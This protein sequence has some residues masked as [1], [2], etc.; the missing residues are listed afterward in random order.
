MR[1]AGAVRRA[2]RMLAAATTVGAAL[3]AQSVAPGVSSPPRVA[4]ASMS[5]TSSYSIDVELDV[6]RHT[7]VGREVITW[8]NASPR[9]TQEI[10][11]HLYW[12]A[13]R[14]PQ[15]TFLREERLAGHG[16]EIDARRSDEWAAIDVSA[17]RL[18]GLGGAP[19][20]DLT[21]RLRY[22]A[23]DTGNPHDRTV[24]TVTLPTTIAP[25]ETTNLA[26][27]WTS[28]V[29][30]T[31]ARTGRIGQY[32]FIA[33]WFPKVGVFEPATSA[34]TSGASTGTSGGWNTH[35]FHSTTEFFA[36]YGSYDVRITVPAGWMVGA[37]GRADSAPTVRDGKAT[38]RYRQ[39]DVHDFAWVTSPDLIERTA[40][41]AHRSLPPVQMRLLLQPE[42]AGQAERH[43]A[44]TRTALRHYG[45]WF[46]P[47]PYGHVTIVDPAWGSESGGMEYPTLF[48]A[49]TRWLAPAGVAEP[50][51]V[52]VHETGHQFWYG[53]VGNNEFE[54]AWLDEGLT[55]FVTARVLAETK[56]PNFHSDRFFGGFVPWTYRDVP[57]P[58][59][60]DDLWSFY[61]V[62]AS[63]DPPSAPSWR[64]FPKTGAE[65]TYA[66]TALWLHT[67]EK[68][69]G[70]PTLE[71]ILKTFFER[72]RFRHP[73]P[74]D[75]FA[76]A[77]EVSG[78]DLTWF[79]DEVYRS[80]NV[81]DYAVQSLTSDQAAAAGYGDDA[82]L[83]QSGGQ[84]ARAS[85]DVR[86]QTAVVV[87][88]E[89]AAIFPV[90]LVV[91]FEDGARRRERW[92]GRER[93]RAFRY[94]TTA[95]AVSAAVDPEEVLRLDVDRTNNSLSLAPDGERAATKWALPWLVWLQDRLLTFS[96]VF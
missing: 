26:V 90:D 67:L 53:L 55:T 37:T 70:W 21:G 29:P 44:A 33:Q 19:P 10:Q 80:S 95:R 77:N 64:Y 75:F 89:G 87:R 93:W 47:Y 65:I 36:D 15:S 7:L 69:L 66:K 92:D 56:T 8:R 50:E 32:Y 52:T 27:E 18:L 49:G 71:R 78:R 94:E 16:G 12:N 82:P 3:H 81:F 14:N 40:S 28:R 17:I 72:W 79:F 48:T 86:Y 4:S 20:I 58:R 24:A 38:H 9:P 74:E 39:D 85:A 68:M 11:L 5:H 31:F 57:L 35:E 84:T 41:F 51:N 6:A 2:G 34:G 1:T 63:S 54:H 43:F 76:V 96:F 30:R 83:A 61:R 25:G 91:T 60:E 73:R 23:P 59:A 62:A 13:W 42:H 46:G 45:E 88:R 22:I